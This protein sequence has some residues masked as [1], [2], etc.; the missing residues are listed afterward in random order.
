MRVVLGSSAVAGKRPFCDRQIAASGSRFRRAQP[1]SSHRTLGSKQGK[2]ISERWDFYGRLMLALAAEK[3]MLDRALTFGRYRLQPQ[4]GLMSGA[5]EIRLTPK[6][7]ALLTFLAE[8][9]GKVISKEE[10]FAAVWPGVAVGDAALVTCIQELRKALRDN[11]R[12]PRLYRDATP[13]RLSLHCRDNLGATARGC[14]RAR[15][16]GAV[17]P[18]S[19]LD[20]R[21][22][23]PQHE[24]RSRARLLCRRHLGRSHHRARPHPLAVRDR[25]QLDLRLQKPQRGREAGLARAWRPLRARRQRSPRRAQAAH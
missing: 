16:P 10:L 17:A 2:V 19:A 3:M 20:R 13:T 5:R 12:H 15:R 6:A 21:A 24:R 11:A 8:R 1:A 23:V 18:R 25:P 9:P 22:A 4:G 7:L 14:L